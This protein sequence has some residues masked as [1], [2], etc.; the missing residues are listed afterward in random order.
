MW[1]HADEDGEAMSRRAIVTPRASVSS[2]KKPGQGRRDPGRGP[3]APVRAGR[4][5][6]N[7]AATAIALLLAVALALTGAPASSADSAP[8]DPNDPK[9]PVTVT[10]DSLPTAQ[11]DG[12]AWQTT[13]I[14]NTVYV[15]GRF[16]NARPFGAAPGTQQVARS[17]ILAF[18]L[19]T[20]QLI[21]GF[22]PVLNAQALSIAPSPDG[23]RI[24][25]GG[26]FT[27]VNGVQRWRVAALDAVTGNLIDS[28]A[29]KMAAGVRGIAAH[30]NTVWM[31]GT[32]NAVGSV[33]R[34]RLAAVNAADGAL[35]PW[36]PVAGNGKVNALTVS[37]DGTKV[38]AGG[39]FTTL[40][41]SNR[42]GYG[43]GM[44]NAVTGANLPLQANDVVRDGG[45]DSAVLS[46]ASDGTNFYGTGYIYGTG[47]NLEGAF[48]AKWSDG[49][50]TWVEDCHGDSYGVFAN[51]T[52]VYV[53]GHPH[54]C[55]NLGG[56]PEVTPRAWHRAVAFS[57]AATGT[58]T[59]DTQGYPSFPGQPAPSLLN[60]FPEVDNGSASGQSQGPWAVTGNNDYVVM[61]GEFRNI[62]QQPQQGLARFARTDLAP[63]LQ[64]PRVSGSEFVPTLSS[65]GSGRIRVQW[66]SN[67]D[68]DNSN[69]TYSVFRDS[70]PDPVYAVSSQ[71]TF[72]QRPSL[73]YEDAGLALG[74]H[75]YRIAVKDPLGNSVA[76]DSRSITI[77]GS[78]NVP[79]SASFTSSVN[80]LAVAVDA[81][82]STDSDGTISS[83]AWDFGD[84][85]TGTGATAS[86]NYA[87][88]GGYTITLTVTDNAGATATS[89]RSVTVAA[90]N[91]TILAQDAFAR[92]QTSGWG[93]ADAGGEWSVDGSPTVYFVT[94]GQGVMR[95]TPGQ[96]PATFLPAVSSTSSNSLVTV[97]LDKIG[98]GGGT[99]L[100]LSGR[101]IGI[102]E[103]R[104]KVKVSATG[105]IALR[106]TRHSG[107][108]ETTLAQSS[109]GITLTAGQRLNL[110]VEVTGIA[111]TTVRARTWLQGT[112]EPAS[113]DLSVTDN[114]AGLQSAGTVGMLSYLSGSASN[115]PVLARFDDFE[116]TPD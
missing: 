52:A 70:A 93:A 35:L 87:A 90:G 17:N 72:W 76:G 89:S 32:F 111:P 71:S 61:V 19:T 43:L 38:V 20:G 5:A 59:E 34:P 54:Y 86:H 112:P 82:A 50:I 47:G 42:P 56:F 73:S 75:S 33:S 10:A 55:Q 23:S 113:W 51:E 81:S 92:T 99:Y 58:L 57:K 84:G 24:Y 65:P 69:L 30:G 80:G 14:G 53:A 46:L 105:S 8:V 62:N 15:A 100:G 2:A 11:H 37:P 36:N 114:T 74:Q 109:P 18:N 25:V 45:R 1:I 39:A 107:T 104:G 12:V 83:H 98:N 60:W 9:T 27:S 7:V 41:G 96:G 63:N 26:D 66:Q 31:G 44:V 29:P 108:S 77:A 64:G 68:R 79:P 28:F 67:W 95:L 102:A 94:G 49:R 78:N 4:V 97:S 85:G 106:L 101:R 40:N 115:D 116:V 110:R 48:S 6:G 91:G 22:A 103:Y 21:P 3:G 16:N 88:G 13:V